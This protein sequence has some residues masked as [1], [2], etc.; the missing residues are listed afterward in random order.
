MNYALRM[1]AVHHLLP[2]FPPKRKYFIE[3]EK[4]YGI[5]L[6]RSARLE[7]LEKGPIAV[8][9]RIKMNNKQAT[10]RCTGQS[11]SFTMRDFIAKNHAILPHPLLG[12]DIC[13]LFL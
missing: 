2:F 5:M 10:R 3:Y 11:S 7:D 12:S 6:N 8:A 4:L 1:R 9:P 13:F